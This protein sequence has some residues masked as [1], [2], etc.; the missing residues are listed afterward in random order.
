MTNFFTTKKSLLEF[1]ES[2]LGPDFTISHFDKIS[3]LP[4]DQIIRI[5]R[6]LR[7]IPKDC[8]IHDD[9]RMMI[10]IEPF[11]EWFGSILNTDRQPEKSNTA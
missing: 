5:L 8:F 1:L 2:I 6:S 9:N 7:Q 10:V 3:T 11:L 4:D